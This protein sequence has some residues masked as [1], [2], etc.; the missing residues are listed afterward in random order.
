[1]RCQ[2][3]L[4]QKSGVLKTKGQEWWT[5][6]DFAHSSEEEFARFLDFY[7]IEWRYEP[8]CFPI[9]RDEEG[10]V[11]GSFTPDFYLPQFDLYIELTTMKQ[12]LVTRKNRKIRKMRQLY[13][14]LNLKI[15]YGRDYRKLLFKFGMLQ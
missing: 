7:K 5:V 8:A 13:P 6:P 12:R 15:L 14:E 3:A 10:H 4:V 2:C 11:V 1:L 9:E